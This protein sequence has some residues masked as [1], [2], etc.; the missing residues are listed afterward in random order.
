MYFLWLGSAKISQSVTEVQKSFYNFLA[1]KDKNKF[2]KMTDKDSNQ[3]DTSSSISNAQ[4]GLVDW[5]SSTQNDF[6][7][8][9]E[10]SK[11]LDELCT[12]FNPTLNHYNISRTFNG[13]EMDYF[14][15]MAHSLTQWKE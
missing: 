7:N 11:F 4:A 13:V 14:G 5:V 15:Y 10:T 2:S 8:W 6:C 1:K 12:M 9:L 3:T